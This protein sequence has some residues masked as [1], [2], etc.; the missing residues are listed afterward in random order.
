ME[1]RG[2]AQPPMDAVV[3]WHDAAKGCCCSTAFKSSSKEHEGV[4]G[5]EGRCPCTLHVRC[6]LK[7]CVDIR[8]SKVTSCT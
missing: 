5:E 7:H 6:T 3:P 8:H 2:A 4:S 1:H